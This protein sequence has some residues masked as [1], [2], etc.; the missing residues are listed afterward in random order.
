MTTSAVEKFKENY[1]RANGDVELPTQEVAPPQDNGISF[2]IRQLQ[3]QIDELA[4]MVQVRPMVAEAVAE[5]AG[6][7]ETLLMPD[8]YWNEEANRYFANKPS[9]KYFLIAN[10]QALYGCGAMQRLGKHRVINP[11]VFREFVVNGRR[12]NK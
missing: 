8:I 2:T 10:R 3:R 11:P 4:I 6:R 5:N 7:T 12:A 9:F 1:R